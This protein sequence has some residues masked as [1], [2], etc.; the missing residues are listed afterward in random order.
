M[1]VLVENVALVGSG[2]KC[3]SYFLYLANHVDSISFSSA[4]LLRVFSTPHFDRTLPRR[5]R[6]FSITFRHAL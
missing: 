5:V 1:A 3:V 4:L 6:V 2:A